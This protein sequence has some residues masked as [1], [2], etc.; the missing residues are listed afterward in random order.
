VAHGGKRENAGRKSKSEEQELIEKLTPM[1]DDA[2]KALQEAVKKKQNWAV[3]LFFEYMYGKPK[4]R[5]EQSN[6]HQFAENFSLESL[7]GESK[8]T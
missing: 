4:Q 7:Y 5:I 3:K 2:F 1:Q 8:E 6:L